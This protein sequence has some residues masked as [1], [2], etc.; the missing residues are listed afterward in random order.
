MTAGTI[1]EL[2]GGHI[3]AGEPEALVTGVGVDTRTLNVGDLFVALPGESADGHAFLGDAVARGAAAVLVREGSEVLVGTTVLAVEDPAAGL[4]RLATGVRR[5]L[6]ARV[7]AITG[8][9][10]KT[11]TK[12]LTAAVARA[13]FET[14]ASAASFNNE[15][16]VPL[17]ILAADEGTE[18]LVAEV[19]AR[20]IGHIASLMPIVRPDVGVVLNVGVAHVG[21]FGSTEAIAQAKGE[22]VEALPAGGTAILNADDAVVDTMASR[23]K[24]TVLRFGVA[25]DADVRA[26]GVELGPDASAAFTLIAPDGEADVRLRIPG[27]H[28]VSDALAAAAVGVALGIDVAAIAGALSSARGPAW[29]MEVAQAPGGWVVVNDAYNANPQSTAAALKTLVRMGRGRRTWAVLGY[30]AELGD[31]E[32]AEHDRI[33]RLAVRLG[34]SR[35]IAVGEETRPLYEAARL[36]GMTPEEAAIVASGDEALVQLRASLEPG[37]VVLVKASRAVGL[38]A[39]A[40]A[41]AEGGPA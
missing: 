4:L 16:G 20:G 33:G 38:H 21:L 36:E 26:D 6:A 10:G 32:S 30:M 11:I 39:V 19:G 22:L 24:A 18:V 12:E 40:I 35:L 2:V 37:D 25:G 29:R 5:T 8:S 27:E 34:V 13:R 9:S 41:L 14:V 3:V 31:T 17:T 1:A 28:I 15:I 23:T 7:V